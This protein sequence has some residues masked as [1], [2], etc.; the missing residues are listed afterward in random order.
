M[1]TRFLKEE[2]RGQHE[3]TTYAYLSHL[4]GDTEVPWDAE[5]I[6]RTLDAV[7]D[8]FIEYF[9]DESL[10]FPIALDHET[11]YEDGHAKRPNED[12]ANATQAFLEQIAGKG[13]ERDT[14]YICQVLNTATE[15]L[16]RIGIQI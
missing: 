6:D 10:A 4:A 11:V 9:D 3:Q 12:A 13:L 14:W 8:V 16:N 1:A 5:A 7:D 15:A 2:N